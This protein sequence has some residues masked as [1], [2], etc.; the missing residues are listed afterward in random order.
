MPRKTKVRGVTRGRLQDRSFA[1]DVCGTIVPAV[2]LRGRT[3]PGHVKHMY[4]FRCGMVT[5][6]TQVG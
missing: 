1:C 6:H 4:C 2:K 5:Q 3:Q